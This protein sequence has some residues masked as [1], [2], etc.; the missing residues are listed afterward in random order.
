MF[1]VIPAVLLVAII[2]ARCPGAAPPAKPEFASPDAALR[3][4]QRGFIEPPASAQPRVYWWSMESYL[5][6]AGITRDLEEM[7]RKGVGGV[8]LFDAGSGAHYSHTV[9]QTPCGP[10][11]MSPAWRAL[12]KHTLTEADRLGLEIRES[13]P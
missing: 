12:F 10:P 1:R 13:D 5:D 8:L 3:D 4:L 6:R 7:K 2:A 9:E 11:F